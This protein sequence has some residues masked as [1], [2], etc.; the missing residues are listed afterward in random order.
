[1]SKNYFYNMVFEMEYDRVFYIKHKR[2]NFIGYFFSIVPLLML[3]I[4][5]LVNIFKMGSHYELL[6]RFF[7]NGIMKI[8][9][10]ICIMVFLV[11]SVLNT[12]FFSN[13]DYYINPKT[14]RVYLIDGLWKFR[15]EV[16]LHFK[17]LKYIVIIQNVDLLSG[18]GDRCT[19]S[20]DIYDNEL[21]AYE[22]CRSKNYNGINKTAVWIGNLTRVEVIDR[23]RIKNYE[24]FKRRII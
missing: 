17:Q 1:M 23:S 16:V 24:G 5:L 21:N 20:I 6:D 9:L 18:Y 14:K 15:Q 11:F 13:C 2:K 10:T 3:C 12:L 8:V 7:Q 22:V 4:F 19:Y